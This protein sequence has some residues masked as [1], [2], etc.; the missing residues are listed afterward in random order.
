MSELLED[1]VAVGKD[2]VVLN[3]DHLKFDDATLN[4]FLMEA[5]SW[6]NYYGQKLADAE[7]YLQWFE[8]KYDQEYSKKFAFHKE[9]GCTEKLAESKSKT[10]TEVENAKNASIKA[11]RTVGKLKQFIRAMDKAHESAINFGYMLRKEMDKTNFRIKQAADM[12]MGEAI[13]QIVKAADLS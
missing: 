6:Y 2:K 5:A 10:D 13:D 9:S 7:S 12:E 1:S 4:K 3:P 11:K 8:T